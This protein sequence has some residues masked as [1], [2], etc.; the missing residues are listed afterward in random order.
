MPQISH[1]DA[2]RLERIVATLRTIKSDSTRVINAVRQLQQL[3]TKIKK[4]L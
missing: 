1:T 3:N 2:R 4:Q